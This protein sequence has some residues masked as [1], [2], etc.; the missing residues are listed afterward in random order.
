MHAG[1]QA[2]VDGGGSGA[3][4]GVIGKKR[5]GEGAAAVLNVNLHVAGSVFHRVGLSRVRLA[6]VEDDGVLTEFQLKAGD[7]VLAGHAQAGQRWKPGVNDAHH[8]ADKTGVEAARLICRARRWRGIERTNRAALDFGRVVRHPRARRADPAA[9]GVCHGQAVPIQRAGL[10]VITSNHTA[11][12]IHQAGPQQAAIWPH[13]QRQRPGLIM[14]SHHQR[15]RTLGNAVTTP[16][17]H[18]LAA[19]RN[20]NGFGSEVEAGN[21]A[22][23]AETPTEDETGFAR[24]F[25]GIQVDPD[26]VH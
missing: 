9:S 13:C 16:L 11:L 5:Q 19:A 24:S 14:Y 22:R 17:L 1:D 7:G 15:I 18:E 3:A 10:R 4:E 20:G 25:H 8:H 12:H 21:A 23:V 26:H 6:A 2:A